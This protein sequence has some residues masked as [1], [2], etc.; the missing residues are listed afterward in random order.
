MR[1]WAAAIVGVLLAVLVSAGWPTATGAAET[2]RADLGVD[3]KPASGKIGYEIDV[4]LYLVNNGPTLAPTGFVFFSYI[5]PS[6]TEILE[7]NFKYQSRCTWIKPRKHVRC[8]S[9]GQY[10]VK[11]EQGGADSWFR[12]K[13]KIVSRVTSPGTFRV[14]CTCDPKKSNNSTLIVVNGV[15]S[16]IKPS[17]KPSVTP[18]ASA[19]AIPSTSPLP[20]PTESVPSP[21]D[22]LAVAP[23]EVIAEPQTE[24]AS[25]T[26]MLRGLGFGAVALALLGLGAA[27][28]L[29]RSR[30]GDVVGNTDDEPLD[31]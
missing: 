15:R 16:R 14:D 1:R 8:Q 26:G 21:T 10:W 20:S 9:G 29:W 18:I 28:F 30:R 31:G 3:S 5:A 24:K 22:A 4:P 12:L 13:L 2:F 6:G 19:S 23:T 17:A 11:T 27:A 7:S 25:S